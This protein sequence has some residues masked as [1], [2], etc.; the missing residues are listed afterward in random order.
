MKKTKVF[1]PKKCPYKQ[2]LEHNGIS[3]VLVGYTQRERKGGFS[4]SRIVTTKKTRARIGGMAHCKYT[5]LNY[6]KDSYMTSCF[7]YN[8]HSY[9]QCIRAMERYDKNTDRKIIHIDFYNEV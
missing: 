7:T 4:K 8:L 9:E 2:L 5:F 1:D 6:L 3:H